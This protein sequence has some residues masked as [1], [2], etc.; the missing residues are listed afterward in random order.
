MQEHEEGM[1]KKR[2]NTHLAARQGNCA[3]LDRGQLSGLC[4]QVCPHLLLL[5]LRLAGLFTQVGIGKLKLKLLVASH[6]SLHLPLSGHQ[7]LPDRAAGLLLSGQIFAHCTVGLLLSSQLPLKPPCTTQWQHLFEALI[8][9]LYTPGHSVMVVMRTGYPCRAHPA[10][11][12]ASF[13][14][15]AAASKKMQAPGCH[16]S[17][18]P[19]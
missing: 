10:K 15:A 1:G 5:H 7:I 9:Q 2:Q 14:F 12:E 11:H 13:Q 17:R 19:S 4:L 18:L 3:H 8:M 16:F 6:Q